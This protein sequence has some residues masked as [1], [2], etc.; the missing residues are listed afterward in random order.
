MPGH[1]LCL[2][3]LHL[4]IELLE[5]F[6]QALYQAPKRPGQLVASI[7]YELRHPLG[8]VVSSLGNDE[9]ELS[10]QAP[11]LVG[12]GGAG[13]DKPLARPVQGQHALLLD[14]LDRHK[15][16]ARARDGFTDGLGIG[17][18]VFVGLDVGLDELWRHQAHGV[19][20]ALEL[21]GPVVGTAA[22]LHA[23]QAGGQIDKETRHLLALERF[24][25]HG[26]AMLINAVDLK[27]IL[28][29]VD[30]NG[31]NLHGGRSCWFEWNN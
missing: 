1:N 31:C 12:L 4:A 11:N 20:H 5:V 26:L 21:A 22:G 10:E 24:V 2:Q 9:S 18:I 27:H 15:A 7:L 17:R 30:A 19:A 3:L 29:Q 28:G 14:I 16:H 8:D 25:E 6:E 13:L 23:N